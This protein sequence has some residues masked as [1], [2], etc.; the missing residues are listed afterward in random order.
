MGLNY[1]I[2]SSDSH[3]GADVLGYRDYLPSAWHAEFDEWAKDY[4]SPWDDLVNDTASKNWDSDRRTADM[5]AE[6]IAAEVIFPN[7]IPPFF[8]S[9][10]NIV[11]LPKDQAAFD[12]RWAGLQAHNRWV[13][14]FCEQLPGRR[15]AFLQVFPN[16]IAAAVDEVRWGHA[17]GVVCGVLLPAP[18]ANHPAAPPLYADHYEPLWDVCEELDLPVAHHSGSG[19]AEL[20][21]DHWATGAIMATE[22]SMFT[23]RSLTHMILGGV[24]E[25]H[26]RLKFTMTEQGPGNGAR[27]LDALF[28]F[29]EKRPW[30]KMFMRGA[31]DN[32]SLLPSEYFQRNCYVGASVVGPEGVAVAKSVGIDRFMW[33]TDYPHRE[34]TSPYSREALRLS[35]PGLTEAECRSFL[36]EVAA[37]IYGFDLDALAPIAAE[38]GPSVDELAQPL[39][40]DEVPADSEWF[41]DRAVG[42]HVLQV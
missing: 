14:D 11:T 40:E 27:E 32:L 18:P 19:M 8:E 36:G 37:G 21:A 41:L 9:I 25:R 30:I 23:N 34:A 29:A 12:R 15:R 22:F 13:V 38:W 31:Q 2:V 7:T 28:H 24:F 20:V 3:A 1:T 35:L 6:G 4:A 39:T 42:A 17:T 16:D 5:N 33:G 10:V 26:P